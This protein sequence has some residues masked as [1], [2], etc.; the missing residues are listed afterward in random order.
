MKVE[1]PQLPPASWS[2]NAR[3]HW[4]VRYQEGQVYRLAVFYSCVDARNKLER[5][6]WRPGFPPF[7]RA[8]LNLSFVFATG[9]KRDEDNLRARFKP[10]QDALVEAGLIKDDAPEHLLMGDIFIVVDK[11]RAPLTIIELKEVSDG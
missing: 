8:K 9:R 10:G 1:V 7:T 5:A 6:P 3:V 11:E 4:R 2:P